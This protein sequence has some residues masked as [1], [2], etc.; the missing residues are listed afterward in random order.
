[1]FRVHRPQGHL[2]GDP[3]IRPLEDPVGQ[4]EELG[5]PLLA[6]LKAPSGVSMK[7]RLA[8]VVGLS[9]AVATAAREVLMSRF[10]PLTRSRRRIGSDRA[11]VIEAHAAE[12][13]AAAVDGALA[14][15]G[16]SHG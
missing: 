4:A 15:L 8:G 7:K 11:A 13:M 9:A 10:D 2:L 16:A 6:S 14:S 1:M 5:G 3:L 12:E